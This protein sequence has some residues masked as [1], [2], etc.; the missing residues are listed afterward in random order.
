MSTDERDGWR[1]LSGYDQIRFE[2]GVAVEV[3][4]LLACADV[5]LGGHRCSRGCAPADEQTYKY[6][7]D[8]VRQI[9][10]DRVSLGE[11]SWPD[12][13][14]NKYTSWEHIALVSN[15]T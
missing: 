4:L 13:E 1:P 9:A 7:E 11:R 14:R 6:I 2:R 5:G 10:G 3:R 15:G 8:L 12:D